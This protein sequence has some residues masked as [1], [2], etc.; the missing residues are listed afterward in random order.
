MKQK[1]TVLILLA[2]AACVTGST[3]W[4]V[5]PAGKLTKT[6][7][8]SL[9][10]TAKTPADHM[11]LANYYR[12]EANRLEADVKEHEGMAAAYDK[13]PMAHPIPKGQTLG[14]HCRNLM[15]YYG[16]GASDANAMAAMHEEMAKAAK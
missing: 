10:R 14:D 16:E 6:Q 9:I 3:A 4:A 8:M 2:V 13:N 7:L 11:K 12:Y 15:K 1:L 5:E